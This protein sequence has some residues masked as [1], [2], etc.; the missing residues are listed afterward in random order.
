MSTPA[1]PLVVKVGGSLFDRVASLIEVFH[2]VGRPVLIVPGGGKFVELVRRLAVPETPA[3]WMAIAGMEQFGWYIASHGV[4]ATPILALPAET[5]VLLPY[6]AL[7]EADPLPH[8][9]NVTSDTI[10]AWVAKELSADL[11]LLKSVDGIHHRRRL[12]SRVEDPGIISDEVDPTFIRFVF[13]H[14]LV[15]RVVNGRHSD[16]LRQALRDETVIGTLLDPRF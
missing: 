14:G 6:C 15:A 9:W 2:E 8:S 12:L 7:R 4:P 10:A 3:H 13:E 1:P 5:T 11:L 16:R